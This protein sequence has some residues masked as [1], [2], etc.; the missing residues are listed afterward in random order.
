[1][2]EKVYRNLFEQ[3]TSSGNPQMTELGKSVIPGS[4][5][6]VNS[7]YKKTMEAFQSEF[8]DISIAE[9]HFSHHQNRRV[10]NLLR[11]QAILK[12]RNG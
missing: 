11:I 5:I 3:K 4:Q 6:P 8:E 1:M 9:L 2:A 12:M 10:K 7:L